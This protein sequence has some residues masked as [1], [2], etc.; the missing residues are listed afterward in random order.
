V[1]SGSLTVRVC[2]AEIA[3]V[4]AGQPVGE[5][6][7]LGARVANATVEAATDTRLLILDNRRLAAIAST[8]PRVEQ[9]LQALVAERQG[10]AAAA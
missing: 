6:T 3:T 7:A 9:A 10:V 5:R 4:G 2:G 1:V 8:N